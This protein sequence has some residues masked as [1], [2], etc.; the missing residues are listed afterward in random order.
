MMEEKEEEGRLEDEDEDEV[1]EEVEVEDKEGR[2]M[3]FL[4]L[5]AMVGVVAEDTATIMT[6]GM[7]VAVDLMSASATI[8]GKGMG[9]EGT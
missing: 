9:K 6:E 4:R 3:V 1:V 7:V 8:T 2:C 5:V